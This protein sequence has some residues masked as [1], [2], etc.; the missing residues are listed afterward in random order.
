MALVNDI[1]VVSAVAS[2]SDGHALLLRNGTG[3]MFADGMS[4][5]SAMGPT[6]PSLPWSSASFTW[7]F[8]ESLVDA[9]S[10]LVSPSN[11]TAVV[12]GMSSAVPLAV[13]VPI[14]VTYLQYYTYMLLI[15]LL[16]AILGVVSS[17]CAV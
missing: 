8:N 10:Y 17:C 12:G 15:V 16:Q 14:S 7:S 13:P 1:E 5:H 3:V 6:S 9:F 11:A 2:A 4:V